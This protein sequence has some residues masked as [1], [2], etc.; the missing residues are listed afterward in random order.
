MKMEFYFFEIRFP[1]NYPYSPPKVK[2]LT[3]DGNTRMHPNFYSCG[4]VCVSII[5][6]WNGPGWTSCQTLSSVLITFRSL[7]IKNPLWQEPGFSDEKSQRNSDYNKL[8]SYENIRISILKMISKTPNGFEVFNDIVYQH[9]LQNKDKITQ[10][11]INK[12]SIKGTYNSPQIYSFSRNIDYQKMLEELD[13]MYNNLQDVNKNILPKNQ[14]AIDTLVNI[15][16]DTIIP[17]KQLLDNFNK[18]SENEDI[19][20]DT[21]VSIME[22]RKI[23]SRNP[24][25]E[26]SLV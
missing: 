20:F 11:C 21:I 19:N 13:L 7:F 18:L 12:K 24:K 8:I 25:G 15:I 3:N 5:G 4:K 2:F 1:E 10:Q 14:E 6:T 22:M 23:I 16:K 26:I 9:L 17:Y